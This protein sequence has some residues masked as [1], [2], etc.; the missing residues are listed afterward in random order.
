MN[1]SPLQELIARTMSVIKLKVQYKK[2]ERTIERVRER[3][4][5]VHTK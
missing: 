2:K 4:L 1:D 5:V 3:E